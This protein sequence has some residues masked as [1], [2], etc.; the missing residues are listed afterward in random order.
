MLEIS[1]TIVYNGIAVTFAIFLLEVILSGK[2]LNYWLAIMVAL[3][4]SFF[5]LAAARGLCSEWPVHLHT[6]P[7]KFS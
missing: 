2:E 6:W 5:L 4:N 3:L 7:Q 1:A